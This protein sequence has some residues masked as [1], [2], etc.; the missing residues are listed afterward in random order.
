M[1]HYIGM[2]SDC[3]FEGTSWDNFDFDH[4]LYTDCLSCHIADAPRLHYDGQCSL[5]H[6]VDEWAHIEFYHETTYTD[7]VYCHVDDAPAE[8][9]DLQCSS[10]HITDNWVVVDYL[11]N[12][13]PFE[14]LNCHTTPEEE[15]YINDCLVCHNVIELAADQLCAHG[16]LPE[17]LGVPRR[18]RRDTGLGSARTATRA[19]ATG[20]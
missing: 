13:A 2:C 14:C 20:R 11:H 15:H 6:F 7:C 17:L 10:C 19:P 8:H 1:N 5:C 4:T 18:R 3:H 12:E 9:Y 16:G